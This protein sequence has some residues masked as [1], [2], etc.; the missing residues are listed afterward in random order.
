MTYFNKFL[1]INDNIT[2]SPNNIV[3]CIQEDIKYPSLKDKI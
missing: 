2:Q 1:S 3:S